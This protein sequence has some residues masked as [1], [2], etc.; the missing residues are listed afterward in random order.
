MF[1]DFGPYETL[2]VKHTKYLCTH[3]N[4]IDLLRVGPYAGF[5]KRGFVYND[6][7][8]VYA[9]STYEETHLRYTLYDCVFREHN[10]WCTLVFRT[11]F[12]C[13]LVC[14]GNTHWSIKRGVRSNS[15]EPPLRTG[16]Q[17]SKHHRLLRKCWPFVHYI[18]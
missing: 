7:P 1:S 6:I 14:S 9:Q 17:M 10:L 15:L 11:R 5:L 3:E 16:L 4:C 13:V 12:Y 2:V 8:S 18:S